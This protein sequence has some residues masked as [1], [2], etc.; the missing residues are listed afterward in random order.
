M[1][2]KEFKLY[3]LPVPETISCLVS[4]YMLNTRAHHALVHYYIFIGYPIF[5]ISKSLL[6]NNA[7][8]FLKEL[9]FG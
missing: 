2:N 9:D 1:A 4:P 8:F 3:F 5:L 7:V 6:A